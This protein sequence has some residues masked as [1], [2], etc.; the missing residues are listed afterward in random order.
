M[1]AKELSGIQ[2]AVIPFADDADPGSPSHYLKQPWGAYGAAYAGQLFEVGVLAVAEGH[3]IPVPSPG[4][5]EMLAESF[6]SELGTLADRYVDAVELGCVAVSDL[7]AFAPMI[8]SSIR[9]D[10]EERRLYEALLFAEAGLDRPG[11]LD[12]RRTMLLLLYM[13]RQLGSAPDTTGVRWALYT[14]RLSGGTVLAL[15]ECLER[16]RRRWWVYQANDLSHVCFETLL[17]YALDMLE[18]HPDGIPL[19]RLIPDAV[20]NIMAAAD[21]RPTSWATFLDEPAPAPDGW[22]SDF[23]AAE[24][25]LAEQ[26]LGAAQREGVCGP[27][28]AWAALRLLAVLHNRVRASTGT[29]REELGGFD[30]AA[31]RSL[32]SETRFLDDHLRDDFEA[33][34]ARLIE[35]RVIRRHLQIALRKLRY[36]GDYTFLIEADDGRV[37]LR[38]KMDR[39]SPTRGSAR[40]SPSSRTFISLAKTD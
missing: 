3:Q 40:R 18:D 12:R 7:D 14:G 39:S 15:P 35:E 21:V 6:A 26:A 38:A 29:V 19:A 17:K 32:L 23:R 4:I 37:R 13:A 20:G 22:S 24:E 10:S 28:G 8:P 34:V 27:E 36:Q 5:G 25:D 30:F 1:G 16:Q 9:P 31:F 11:D 2:P 33:M